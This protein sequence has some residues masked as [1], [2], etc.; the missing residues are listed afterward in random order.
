MTH[1]FD[2]R[3]AGTNSPTV[4]VCQGCGAGVCATHARIATRSVRRGSLTGAPREAE[5]RTVLCPV[6]AA[7]EAPTAAVPAPRPARWTSW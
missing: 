2:C 6:C 3:T 1:C 5:A 7:A 4:G